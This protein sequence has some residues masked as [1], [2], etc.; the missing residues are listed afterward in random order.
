[1]TGVRRLAQFDLNLLVVLDA[2]LH[3]KSV[4]R[5]ARRYGTSQPAMSA[6]LRKLRDHFGDALL[7]RV[8]RHMT[9]SP[10]AQALVTPVRE[11]IVQLEGVLDVPAPRTF[12]LRIPVE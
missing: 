2:L 1:M 6:S 12:P 8:G 9:L 5:A 10:H 7:M 3:E 11:T 4:T